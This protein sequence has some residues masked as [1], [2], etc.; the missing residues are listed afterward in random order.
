MKKL[1]VLILLLLLVGC[2]PA[3]VDILG[4]PRDEIDIC[5]K[6]CVVDNQEVVALL[7]DF[8][9]M[10]IEL[11]KLF[12]PELT[13]EALHL[14]AEEEY[15][16]DE[17]PHSDVISNNVYMPLTQPYVFYEHGLYETRRLVNTCEI[18]V[19]CVEQNIDVRYDILDFDYGFN[20]DGGYFN[21]L[22]GNSIETAIYREMKFRM[23]MKHPAYSYLDYNFLSD[24]YI[25]K[26]LSDGVYRE[27]M[28]DDSEHFSFKYINMDSQYYLYY[29]TQPDAEI[30]NIYNPKTELSFVSGYNGF[31]S[32]TKLDN[33][34]FIAELRHAQYGDVLR[35]NMFKVEGWDKVEY[36]YS[37]VYPYSELYLGDEEV[38]GDY[39]I[40]LYNVNWH[41]YTLAAELSDE[42]IA[43][44]GFPEDFSGDVS[45]L[46]LQEK[47][48]EFNAMEDPLVMM[49]LT[50][51]EVVQKILEVKAQY[52]TDLSIYS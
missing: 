5:E 15:M 26:T 24:T 6:N 44:I 10:L 25:L 46:F 49:G 31:C 27:Y 8:D 51:E 22:M 13:D 2:T 33:L 39:D 14:D 4:L 12:V 48:D 30:I 3:P 43:E 34:E 42:D 11:T 17:I 36:R 45:L 21:Y 28:Y 9:D 16:R 18:G 52:D 19:E 1:V 32:V 7:D 50:K 41:Y 20:E 23:D 40:V 37:E 38:F 29:Y 47:L 35:F